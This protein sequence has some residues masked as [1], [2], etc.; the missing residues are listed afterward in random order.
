MKVWDIETKSIESTFVNPTYDS[1]YAVLW[2]PISAD[3]IILGCKNHTLIIY[4]V[5]EYKSELNIDELASKRS[6]AIKKINEESNFGISVKEK[7]AEKQTKPSKV[8]L[9]PTFY[10]AVN[11]NDLVNDMK[12]LLDWKKTGKSETNGKFGIFNVF[13]E[14]E[15]MIKLLDFNG[16]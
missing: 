11:D 8:C 7:P 13:G 2:S 16:K 14:S 4:N 15:D 10:N 1:I 3:Y 6:K 5:N 12:L 9:L